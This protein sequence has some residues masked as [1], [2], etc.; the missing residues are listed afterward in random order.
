MHDGAIRG[1]PGET[2]RLVD[3]VLRQGCRGFPK[4]GSL[5]RLLAKHRQVRN[6]KGLT[7]LSVSQI[8]QWA[9]SFYRRTGRWPQRSS[10]SIPESPGETWMAVNSA[11]HNGCRGFRGGSSLACLLEKHRLV[12]NRKHLS[13][14][15]RTEILR[16]ANAH[17][18]RMGQWPHENSGPVVEAPGETWSG[19]NAALSIGGRGLPGG[20]SLFR[21]LSSRIQKN[22][23]DPTQEKAATES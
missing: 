12:R 3:A 23:D 20:S 15:T 17:Y 1:A 14:L 9:D 16:W 5:S 6:R 4:G 22:G 8:L 18:V 11:L 13:P 7:R 2:W 10:G 21:L 19:V